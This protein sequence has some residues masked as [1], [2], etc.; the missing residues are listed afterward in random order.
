[1]HSKKGRIN[2][3]Y[4]KTIKDLS[5]L[6]E[7]NVA[8]FEEGDKKEIT[9]DDIDIKYLSTGAKVCLY[10]YSLCHDLPDN[11][12]LVWDEPENGLHATRRTKLMEIFRNSQSQT[13]IATHATE[14]CGVLAED[15][16]VYKMTATTLNSSMTFDVLHATNRRLAFQIAE[17]LGLNPSSTLFT[18][19]VVIWVEGPS[20]LVFWRYWLKNSPNN[21]GLI[22]GFD[23]SIM[24]YG[25][26]NLSHMEIGDDVV[27]N[28]L[29]FDL[30][31][32]C[33]HAIVIADSDRNSKPENAEVDSDKKAATTTR[34]AI[35]KLN[36]ERA[37]SATYEVTNCREVE[38]YL[39]DEAIRFAV[40]ELGNYEE[41]DLTAMDIESFVVEQ[42]DRYFEKIE[43]HL[44]SRE[45]SKTIK[46]KDVAKGKSFWGRNNKVAFMRK[47]LEFAELKQE[48]LKH[49]G[50][51]QVD[52]LLKW[53]MERRI[54]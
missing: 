15:C 39:P 50:G 11:A 20:D 10:Y 42:F 23:Y 6:L 21:S 19:N 1:M 37:H 38:N 8:A 28:R 9:S 5:D 54:R 3:F 48:N 7:A 44:L 17:D 31:S 52:R 27:E 40:V 36:E 25:G 16:E 24:M 33:R 53:I 45:V 51:E 35:E 29:G 22:E 47:A 12:I 41:S 30:L 26:Q 2:S 49:N 4:D 32:L 18:A 34:E 13:F 43:S 14:F 46:G